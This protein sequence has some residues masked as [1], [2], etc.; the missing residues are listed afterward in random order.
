[1]GKSLFDRLAGREAIAAAASDLCARSVTDERIKAKY[2]RTDP[3]RLEEMLVDLVCQ[4]TGG[5]CTYS[6]RTM[7][8]A[9][10]GMGVTAA[11][12]DAQVELVVAA[13]DNFNVPKAEQDE[14]LALLAPMRA[15]IVEVES[16]ETGTPLPDTYQNAPGLE[17]VTAARGFASR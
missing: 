6:G 10:A 16:A 1:M 9:H 3:V 17:S 8:E 13:L 11:E 4:A 7:R 14:L 12:F 5:P 2:L 15:D